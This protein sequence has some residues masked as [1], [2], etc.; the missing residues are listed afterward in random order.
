M[1]DVCLENR[2][3]FI[4]K[5]LLYTRLTLEAHKTG[6]LGDAGN[7]LGASGFKGHPQCGFCRRRFFG[8]GELF[9]HMERDHCKCHLCARARPG[10]PSPT[11]YRDMVELQAR[12]ND[13]I[14]PPVP[15]NLARPRGEVRHYPPP[16]PPGALWRGALPLRPPWV[17]GPA[18]CG[19][20]LGAG[21]DGK[22]WAG[23][24]GL[25]NPPLTRR[26]A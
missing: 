17:P 9:V 4:V 8:D 6:P 10:D 23:A 26:D 5:Q 14:F 21:A 18:G 24:L 22:G 3:V 1:C 19:L 13:S 15:R 7:E 11:Y 12:W 25:L 20:C 16:P 2:R